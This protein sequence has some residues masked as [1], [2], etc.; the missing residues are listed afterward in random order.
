MPRSNLPEINSNFGEHNPIVVLPYYEPIKDDV[1]F[2]N[3]NL[4]NLFS[5]DIVGCFVS[6]TWSTR[7]A[8]LDKVLEQLPNLDQNTKDAMK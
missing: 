8:A 6:Q 1:L 3:Q 4:I 2:K 7:Q 5:K